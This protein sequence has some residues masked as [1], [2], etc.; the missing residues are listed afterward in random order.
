MLPD[1]ET[2]PNTPFEPKKRASR[3]P[4]QKS[5]RLLRDLSFIDIESASKEL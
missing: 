1:L 3:L 5:F 2:A 4:L